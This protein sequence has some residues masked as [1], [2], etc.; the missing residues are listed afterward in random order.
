MTNR[1]STWIGQLA[2][3]GGPT[4]ITAVALIVACAFAEGVSIAVLVAVLQVAGLD[5]QNQGAL[6]AFGGIAGVLNSVIARLGL[7]ASLD[8]L[9]LVFVAAAGATALLGR[10]RAVCLFRIDQRFVKLL[11]LRLH[12]AISNA[13]W[14][15]LCRS[16]ATDFTQAITQEASRLGESMLVLLMF[17]GDLVVAVVLIGL[18]FSVSAPITLIVLAAGAT[19]LAIYHGTIREIRRAGEALSEAMR[20]FYGATIEQNQ[21]LKTAKAYGAQARATAL[22]DTAVERVASA[23]GTLSKHQA[24]ASASFEIGATLALALMLLIAGRWAELPS[25]SIL[26]LLVLF[27]R[28]MPRFQSLHQHA[29]NFASAIP[30]FESIAELIARCEQAAEPPPSPEVAAP[31]MARSLRFEKVA[32]EYLPAAGP[33][34]RDVDLVLKRGAV[35]AL[36]GPSGCGKSTL[37]DLAMG[38]LLPCTGR[39]V[40]DDIEITRTNA[41]AWRAHVGYVGPET[42]LFHMSLRENLLWAAP[43]ASNDD[44]NWALSVAGAAPVTLRLPNGIDSPIGDRGGLLSLGERQR[45]GIARA[46]LRRPK[47]LILDEATSG[48]DSETEALVMQSLKTNADKMT[49]LLVAH[50][51]S[52]LRWADTIHVME[53]GRILESGDWDHLTHSPTSRFR[54]FSKAQW[55]AT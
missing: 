33:V 43:H 51:L 32:Y 4:L 27:A 35:V 49:V 15:F 30:A 48:L 44:I 11:R 29:R 17:A 34:V 40:C 24:R 7:Q 28:L 42:F 41:S 50:R 6:G 53:S 39:I 31:S 1:W 36:C 25:A 47:L 52:T 16:R 10:L 22:F 19:L 2:A 38:L 13:D 55:I 9:L 5:G 20:D 45:I 46:L 21:N 37:G 12:R 3:L 26:T 54:E 8:V 23:Y 14:P 18:A